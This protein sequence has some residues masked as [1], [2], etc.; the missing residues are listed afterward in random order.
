MAGETILAIDDSPTV[1]KL[2]ETDPLHRGIPNH[3]GSRRD[4][5]DR[6]GQGEAGRRPRRLRHAQDERVPGLQGDQGNREPEGHADHP[7]HVERRN[8]RLQVR[9]SAGDREYFTKPFQPEDLLEKIR[10]VI[11]RSPRPA[12]A[13]E[14]L[15]ATTEPVITAETVGRQPGNGR[16]GRSGPR[17]P[18]SRAAPDDPFPEAPALPPIRDW[19]NASKPSCGAPSRGSLRRSSRRS[20]V[21]PLPVG[22]GSS[23][24]AGAPIGKE[25]LPLRGPLPLPPARHSPAHLDAKRTGRLWIGTEENQ[26]ETFFEDGRVV[27]AA[28]EHKPPEDLFGRLLMES[29]TDPTRRNSATLADSEKSGVPLGNCSSAGT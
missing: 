13:A 8:R 2:M 9:R 20:S 19:K 15:V 14:T 1:R 11:D 27:F 22:L 4:G 10:E 17:G 26:A 18:R 24:E 25:H 3:H 23:S 16:R 6:Q 7:G 5:R 21:P 29:S 28:L 12:A